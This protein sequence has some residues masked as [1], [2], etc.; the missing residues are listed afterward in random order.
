MAE[1]TRREFLLTAAGGVTVALRR[2][3]SAAVPSDDLGFLPATEMANAI[4]AKKLS[5]VE[6]VDAIFA[7]IH[8]LD[9]RINAYCTLTEDLARR[10]AKEAEA[11]VMRGEELRPLDG[12]PVSIK[13]LLIT[14]GVRTMFGS[15]IREKYVP[16]E[17]A[18]SVTKLGGSGAILIGKTTTPEFGF[19]GITESP[20]TGVTR[21]PWDLSRTCGGSSGGAGAAV[22]AGLGPLAVGTDGG[23]SIRIP[24]ALNGIFGLK[25]SFG[26]VAV[27]PASPVAFLVHV[28]PM[29]RTVRD[30]A[31]MMNA[32][33]GPDERDLL[34]LPAD[35]TDYM[36]ACD[37]GIRGLRVAF[38]PALGYAK[39]NPEVAKLVEA[40]AK[41]FET[42][43]GARV[44]IRDP[45]FEYPWKMFSVLWVTSYGLRL[46]ELLPEWES[47][48]DPNLVKLT[49][50]MTKLGRSDYANA[51]AQKANNWDAVRKFFEGYDL[52]LTPT[53][54][55]T[56]FPVG[57]VAPEEYSAGPD[58]LIPFPDWV[59]FTYPF[60]LTGQPAASVPCGFTEGGLPVG[61]Q[62][63]GKRFADATVL[64]AA[65][66]FESARPWQGR[67][68]AL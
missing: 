48:M 28:G 25:P 61:L 26:R 49:K 33:A 47:R 50:Q 10:K 54:P 52:L 20:L 1:I 62:I 27:Y 41:V 19:Q 64:R 4:R 57:R 43:L 68:P 29:T 30:A 42:D 23:G 16:E 44:E 65:A 40:A 6:I 51:V 14:E 15:H 56:A 53:V 66:A 24:S 45:G 34:S 46:G 18:P 9:S 21:N 36:K 32:M 37:G 7:R 12:I 31:L 59:P 55:V 58:D 39:V 63:V 17:D 3:A 13:D 22:A 11:A 67:R 8:A 35:S 38:S 5:P 2:P 60:N